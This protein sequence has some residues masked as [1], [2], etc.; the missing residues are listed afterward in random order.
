[1][2][3]DPLSRSC[4]KDLAQ[5]K[6]THFTTTQIANVNGH[7]LWFYNGIFAGDACARICLLQYS[8]VMSTFTGVVTLP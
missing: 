6:V 8:F 3:H 2:T 1:M 4:E 5:W 7:R